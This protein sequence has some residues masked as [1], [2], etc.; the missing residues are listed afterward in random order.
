MKTGLKRLFLPPR[1]ADEE[2]TRTARILYVVFLIALGAGLFFIVT[3]SVVNPEPGVAIAI[4]A[5]VILIALIALVIMQKGHVRAAAFF[6]ALVMWLVIT[7]SHFF[8]GGVS[9]AG[10]YS[11]I[12]VVVIA[13]LLVG[14]RAALLFAGLAILAILA[15]AYTEMAGLLPA[16][17]AP[18]N[19]FTIAANHIVTIITVTALLYVA[20]TGLYAALDRAHSNERELARSNIELAAIRHSL[21]L[22]VAELEEIQTQMKKYA[23]ELEHSNQEL[24]DFAYVV[25][26][27]L[28]APLRKI[29]AFGD[30]L[31]T[32]YATALDERGQDYVRRMQNAA[33]RMRELIEDLLAFS[34]ITTQ[35]RPFTLVDLNKVVRDVLN[36]LETRIEELHGCVTVEPLPE[37]EADP[38]HMRQLFQNLVDNALKFHQEGVPPEVV[39]GCAPVRDGTAVITISDNGIGFDPQYSE[40]IFQVFQRLHTNEAYEGTGIGLALCRRIVEKHHGRIQATSQQDQGA[41]FTVTLPTKQSNRQETD[42]D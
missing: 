15:L 39:I 33:V 34:R 37:L 18:L 7:P 2:K 41:T 27:D 38:T 25:S 11:Q 35:A 3:F 29:Q 21:E 30:R 20:L 26:H 22:N 17:L 28:Q 6:F 23:A 40:R 16:P 24:Q 14:R 31:T 36:D 13:G 12:S 19:S 8:F 9:S 5:V 10:A 32:N 42:G 1:F 4:T